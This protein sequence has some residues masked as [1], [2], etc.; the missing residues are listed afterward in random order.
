MVVTG[1]VSALPHSLHR[2]DE[3][4]RGSPGAC[5]K[6][7]MLIGS[8]PYG[9]VLQDQFLRSSTL[10]AQA[11]LT[12]I[13]LKTAELHHFRSECVHMRVSY[14]TSPLVMNSYENSK[15]SGGLLLAEFCE[16]AQPITRNAGRHCVDP[17]L[18]HSGPR[19]NR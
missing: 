18:R 1:S 2:G 14:G 7:I 12:L 19:P 4:S 11:E 10:F 9:V 13:H 8:R 3:N 5:C 17:S 16:D 15:K 6:R